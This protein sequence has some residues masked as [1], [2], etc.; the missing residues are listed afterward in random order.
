MLDW[1]VIS[2]LL[3]GVFWWTWVLGAA[4][5]ARQHRE[6]QLR[7]PAKLAIEFGEGLGSTRPK[8]W[9]MW[10][11]DA[12]L[13]YAAAEKNW[14]VL[15]NRLPSK[16]RTAMAEQR[17]AMQIGIEEY[18]DPIDCLHQL[19]K[20]ANETAAAFKPVR[21]PESDQPVVDQPVSDQP[22]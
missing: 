11:V 16:K 3:A 10:Y 14:W 1:I 9:Q 6:K 8:V 19:T 4:R 22:S 17:L 15:Y 7:L 12:K 5:A 20:V 13:R 18:I 21:K 2:A